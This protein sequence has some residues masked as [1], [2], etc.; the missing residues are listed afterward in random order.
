[1]TTRTQQHQN[2]LDSSV[3]SHRSSLSRVRGYWL[4]GC[5]IILSLISCGPAKSTDPP[6]PVPPDWMTGC[7]RAAL[8]LQGCRFARPTAEG[9]TFGDVCRLMVREGHLSERGVQC[10]AEAESCQGAESCR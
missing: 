8:H 5:V 1:M 2:C 10:L 3:H 9:A 7:D 6:L 4:P